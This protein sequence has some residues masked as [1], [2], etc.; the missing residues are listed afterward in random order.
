MLSVSEFEEK[1][2]AAGDFGYTPY[3]EEGN[4]VRCDLNTRES[5]HCV[6]T[7]TAFGTVRTHM[8]I[9]KAGAS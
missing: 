8:R 7:L 1:R 6:E 2:N 4:G 5:G 9:H 3:A